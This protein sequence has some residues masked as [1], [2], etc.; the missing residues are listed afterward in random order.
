[1]SF[2]VKV[3]LGTVVVLGAALL[4]ILFFRSTE[5]Q[6]VEAWLRAGAESAQ[7]ADAD[8][9][10]AM[11]SPA[12]KSSQGDHAWAVGRIRGTLTRSPGFIEVLG[13]AVQVEDESNAGATLRL[14]G[15]V[16]GNELWRTAFAL[17][18]RKEGGAWKVSSAETLD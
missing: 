3:I 16:G 17:R 5:E 9:V 13:C 6:A 2:Q 10:V 4:F 8:A 1:M 12:F 18:L 15:Y 14:R 7:K 11:L